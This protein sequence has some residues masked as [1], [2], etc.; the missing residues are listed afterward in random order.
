MLKS[1]PARRRTYKS[2]KCRAVSKEIDRGRWRIEEDRERIE[3]E[4]RGRNL[5]DP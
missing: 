3:R 2:M 4:D 5:E 1:H